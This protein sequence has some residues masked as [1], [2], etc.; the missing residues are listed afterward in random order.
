[1]W[2]R[3]SASACSAICGSKWLVS[4]RGVDHGRIKRSRDN[5]PNRHE[6][7]LTPFDV[8]RDGDRGFHV[9]IRSSQCITTAHK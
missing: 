3:P 5:I 9:R 6:Q 2:A 8:P 1:M 4:S 7:C